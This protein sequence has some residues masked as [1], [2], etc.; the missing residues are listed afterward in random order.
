MN[1]GYGA[2]FTIIELILFLAVSG[3]LAVGMLASSQISI[4]NQ[5]YRDTLTGVQNQIRKQ[6]TEVNHVVN[7][8]GDDT[9]ISGCEGLRGASNCTVLGKILQITDDNITASTLVA[10]PINDVAGTEEPNGIP[11]EAEDGAPS[12][13]V[14][15]TEEE[16][17]ALYDFYIASGSV[18]SYTV[19]WQSKIANIGAGSE[20]RVMILRSPATGGVHTYSKKVGSGSSDYVGLIAEDN[21]NADQSL[22]ILRDGL[23]ASKSLGVRIKANAS[24]SG[25]IELMTDGNSTCAV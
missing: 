22:C 23:G 21:K 14:P 19:P 11:M 25:S 18:S 4:A 24:S 12:D 7:L 3:A 1:K 13:S 10:K 16:Y 15:K 8:R 9:D 6:Y 2:G 5:R 20:F 17:F